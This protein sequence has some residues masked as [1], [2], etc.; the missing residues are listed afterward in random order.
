M[1]AQTRPGEA[2]ERPRRGRWTPVLA[3]WTD[4]SHPSEQPRRGS[5]QPILGGG[6]ATALGAQATGPQA[7]ASGAISGLSGRRKAGAWVQPAASPPGFV[8][9][10]K[11]QP[12]PVLRPGPGHDLDAR[13][14]RSRIMVLPPRSPAQRLYRPG[15]RLLG[16][17]IPPLE[18]LSRLSVKPP[19][20]DREVRGHAS[21]ACQWPVGSPFETAVPAQPPGALPACS[22]SSA[23]LAR[24]RTPPGRRRQR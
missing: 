23:C 7:V 9:R 16:T 17:H 22:T 3:R 24:G 18:G 15:W 6:S 12:A 20:R 8:V 10:L 2:A 4:N 21:N 13:A 11:I 5:F 14:L 19:R 1:N